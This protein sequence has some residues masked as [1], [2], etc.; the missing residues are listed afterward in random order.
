MFKFLT[1][2]SLFSVTDAHVSVNCDI[3]YEFDY[4][5]EFSS[6]MDT[7]NKSYSTRE[8]LI[9]RYFIFADNMDYINERNSMNLSYT[10]AMNHFGDLTP[11][12]F[13]SLYKGYNGLIEKNK[14]YR[15]HNPTFNTLNYSTIDWRAEGLVTGVKDQKQ[16]GS[17]WAFSAV[18]TMEGA[19]ARETGN[20]NSLSE[21]DLVDCVPDCDGCDGGWPFLAIDYVIN[22][23]TTDNPNGTNVSGI[24][25]ELSYS[26]KG[27]DQS[28][29][30]SNSTVGGNFVSLVRIP[31]NSSSHLLDAVLTIGPIS[32]AI[33]AEGDFQFYSTGI[34]TSD[35]CSQTELDHAVTIVGYG[36][37]SNGKTYYVIK[38][39]WNTDWGQDGYIYYNADIPNMCGIAQDACYAV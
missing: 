23:S 33:D 24:D 29:N 25:T 5:G 34:F 21:Q 3:T 11:E 6:F 36:K 9:N 20:L 8:Y 13:S 15:Y 2:L 26:Y 39:S 14:T 16:C 30:F 35:T 32:V 17:C 27:F 28:C 19:H 12:E 4:L 18:A 7:Y 10:L 1:L 22:G 31:Q 37:T 38:N